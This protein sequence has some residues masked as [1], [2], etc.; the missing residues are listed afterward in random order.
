MDDSSSINIGF[1]IVALLFLVPFMWIQEG[2]LYSI[3]WIDSHELTIYSRLEK[4]P[5]CPIKSSISCEWY[6][7]KQDFKRFFIYGGVYF[8]LFV[9]VMGILIALGT[10]IFSS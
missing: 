4:A 7:T 6:K 9:I 2:I 3:G 5:D 1:I 10:R 8:I